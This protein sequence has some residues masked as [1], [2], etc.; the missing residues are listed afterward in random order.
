M[1]VALFIVPER[2]VP[3]LNVFVN[4]KALGRAKHLDRLAVEAGVRPLMEFF[5][6]AP[7]EAKAWIEDEGMAPPEGGFPPIEWFPAEDGLT[8][9]CG[10]LSHLA[11]NSSLRIY[12]SSSWS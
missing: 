7:A 11:T 12:G 8:T 3:G 2:E 1:G 4:G 6:Q 10:L 5:S 9:V